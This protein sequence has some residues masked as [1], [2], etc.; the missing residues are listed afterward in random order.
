MTTHI[1]LPIVKVHRFPEHH[2]EPGDAE[3]RSQIATEEEQAEMEKQLPPIDPA[4]VTHT[5]A[6]WIAT[7]GT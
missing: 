7:E 4:L 6:D 3:W 1:K 2:D 5:T